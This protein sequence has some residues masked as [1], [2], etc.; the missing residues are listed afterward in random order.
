MKVLIGKWMS[1]H[2]N[3]KKLLYILIGILVI[4]TV[5]DIFSAMRL[6]IFEIAESNPIYVLTGSTMPLIW[7]NIFVVI[8][9]SRSLKN[10]ISIPKIFIFCMMTLYLSI[11]HGFGIYSNITAGEEYQKNPEGFIED[12]QAITPQEKIQAYGFLVGIVMVMPI[13]IS[14]IAFTIA[15]YF[16]GKRQPKRDKITQDIYKLAK[17]LNMG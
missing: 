7:L 10:S 3:E 15:M 6:P 8:W 16:Y 1:E 4:T 9:Y 11:G 17:K 12:V 5:A 14:F 13:I 2:I